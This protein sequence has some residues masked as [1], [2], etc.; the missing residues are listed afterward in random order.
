MPK[1][2]GVVAREV[3]AGLFL[4]VTHCHAARDLH[5]KQ[6]MQLFSRFNLAAKF[7]LL[8]TLVFLAGMLLSWFALSQALQSKAEGE[9]VSKAQILLKTMNS[10]RQYTS[11][12][13]NKHVK[14]LL[15]QRHEFLSETV[16]GYSAREVFEFF[17]RGDGYEEFQYKEAT[18]N[19][20]NPRDKADPFE[21]R[22]V[23]RFRRQARLEEQTGFRD[24]GGRNLF[25]TARPIRV[26]SESCLECHSTPAAAPA[27]MVK[28]YGTQNGFGWRMGEVVG[29]Q[30]VYVPSEVVSSGGQRSTALV[31]GIFVAIFALA[32]FAI[33]V[34]FRRA[35]IGPLGG[36][37]TATHAL[38]RS[39]PSGGLPRLVQADGPA[40]ADTAYGDE[41]AQLT[42]QLQGQI[43]QREQA[44][45]TL[46]DRQRRL[47]VLI[48][49]TPIACVGWKPD[50]TIISWNPAAAKIFGFDE[51]EIIGRNA[52]EVFMSPDIK[53]LVDEFWRTCS[54]R[55]GAT[56]NGL[57]RSVT[58][59]GRSVICEWFNTPL[60]DE[61][62]NV[63]EFIS[64][65]V[66]VT[67]RNRARRELLEAKQA[68]ESASLAKSQF[69]ANMSHEIR[70]PMN[71][72]LGMTELLLG[73]D[74]A[75]KPR[76][77]AQTI[78]HSGDA[79]RAI[80][81]DILDFSK[82]EA[83]K[84]ALE[85]IPFNLRNVIR[86]VE[87]L[88][89]PRA[90]GKKLE[91]V[92]NVD[93]D[94]PTHVTGDPGRLRQILVNLM[95]NA[96]KFSARGKVAVDVKRLDSG[97]TASE[98]QIC[99]LGFAVADT[100]IGIEPA[101][102]AQLFQPF[103]QADNST[104]RKYG[105]TGLGLAISKQLVEM[106][107]GQMGLESKPGAGSRFHFS[108]RAGIVAAPA[109]PAP[110][111]ETS[112]SPQCAPRDVRVLVIED[113]AVNQEV[114]RAMLQGFG[115]EVEV[116]SNGREGVAAAERAR[117]DV[118]FMDCQM[119]EMD[120]F[121]ATRVLRQHESAGAGDATVRRVPIIALTANAMTGDRERCLATG[122]DDYLAKPFKRE[123]LFKVLMA[124]IP[125][126][127]ARASQPAPEIP[128]ANAHAER[129]EEASPVE[130]AALVSRIENA[131]D[132][133]PAACEPAIDPKTLDDIRAL[134]QPGAP[135][136]LAKL[137]G[138]YLHD[139]PRLVQ[140]MRDEIG[141]RDCS[142][143]QRAAHALKSSSADIGAHT[144]AEMCRQIEALSVAGS[145]GGAQATI[146][147]M[148]DEYARVRA[149]LANLSP[150]A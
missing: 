37:A 73:S 49:R 20:T 100:G 114:A 137:V 101:Q 28:I 115:C 54:E 15:D 139:A 71:G 122:M 35:V 24:V 26:T 13:V 56:R 145:R 68:A 29:S 72:I 104:T 138:I 77:Y 128:H 17:R 63:C 117:F 149:V 142:T 21:A 40:I 124:W 34:F 88:L 61:R 126:V 130:P 46:R 64:L 48:E 143:L 38:S 16:P 102:A 70:T 9:A 94:V 55:G 84:L 98:G 44:E 91:F 103:N 60:S 111:R 75:E 90:R 136:L 113:N 118:I 42:A 57:L 87:E 76:H 14:P 83:G 116:A 1:K 22:L 147:R 31:T 119:P 8:L 85:S 62:G 109:V 27:G 23:E 3:R 33:T 81:D 36:L 47:D 97:Y 150:R 32:A 127:D 95:S 52:F 105:G 86:E 110:P 51:S 144:L 125:A 93:P 4:S 66:D 7:T 133:A 41:I 79:L 135:D 5:A 6:G 80:I 96:I 10:V 134:Q 2:A 69:L 43:A 67:E 120:G 148:A 30:I 107:G 99:R 11:T 141:A 132:P 112:R 106:M 89:A 146:E 18:L 140:S 53:P 19:P 59:D 131:R 108:M 65:A 50:Y 82:I 92:C 25:F 78:Y 58:K 12:N 45:V 129:H 39:G 121:E 74:L 123:Q